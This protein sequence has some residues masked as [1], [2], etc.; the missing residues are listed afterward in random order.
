M[1]VTFFVAAD[2]RFKQFYTGQAWQNSLIRIQ[3]I[4]H[5]DDIPFLKEFFDFFF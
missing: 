5:V 1:L 4:W 3:T 2:N